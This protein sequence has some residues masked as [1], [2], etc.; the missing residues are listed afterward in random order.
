MVR[1]LKKS[2]VGQ[3]DADVLH[4]R[5]VEVADH[6][7]VAGVTEGQAEHDHHPEDGEQPHGEDVLHQHAEDVLAPHHA[8]VEQREPWCHEQHQ[9]RGHQHPG[10]VPGIDLHISSLSVG[11][12]RVRLEP[13]CFVSVSSPAQRRQGPLKP[14]RH[15][16]FVFAASGA[17]GRDAGGRGQP[18][19]HLEQRPPSPHVVELQADAGKG[20][21]QAMRAQPSPRWRRSCP[22]RRRRRRRAPPGAPPRRGARAAGPR[23]GTRAGGMATQCGPTRSTP[24]SSTGSRARRA[25]R[26]APC[27]DAPARRSVGEPSRYQSSSSSHSSGG[28][29]PAST[30][31]SRG[32]RSAA[33]LRRCSSSSGQAR[34]CTSIGSGSHGP[35]NGSFTSSYLQSLPATGTRRWT[36]TSI[37]PALRRKRRRHPES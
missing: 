8:G 5:E 1:K 17:A 4:E 2:S 9:G 27:P 6:A 23:E 10:C 14:E 32:T 16:S 29:A 3:R 11:K 18:R 37:L 13:R 26:P 19:R 20:L 33:S 36:V 7:P 21:G 28:D 35:S 24:P 25:A 31:S 15:L 22:L 30:R 12:T 34:T